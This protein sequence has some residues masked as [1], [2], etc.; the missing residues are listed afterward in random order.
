MAGTPH[1]E[2]RA[3]Q[4]NKPNIDHGQRKPFTTPSTD[5]VVYIYI[6]PTTQITGPHPNYYNTSVT[7]GDQGGQP[8]LQPRNR[9]GS[10]QVSQQKDISSQPVASMM[11]TPIMRGMPSVGDLP[12]ALELIEDTPLPPE[13]SLPNTGR[14]AER[15]SN[16]FPSVGCSGR[17]SVPVTPVDNALM[18]SVC[19]SGDRRHSEHRSNYRA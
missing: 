17:I 11:S 18:I 8:T 10:C 5:L 16:S 14:T 19:K 1:R 15:G 9:S 7:L 13:P 3:H 2:S 4:L 6:P 12:S